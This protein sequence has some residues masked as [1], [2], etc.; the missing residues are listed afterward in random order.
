MG[1]KGGKKDKQKIQK[2]SH[3]KD[4]Q[5]AKDKIEKQQKGPPV[6]VVPRQR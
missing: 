2:Q 5:K 1:D 3:N 4:R 6:L